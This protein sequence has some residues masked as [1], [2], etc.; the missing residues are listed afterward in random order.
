MKVEK[1][2][3][4]ELPPQASYKLT[5]ATLLGSPGF[6]RVWREAGGLDVCWCVVDS[7]EITTVMTGVEFRRKP[8]IRFQSMPDGLYCRPV[9]L[10]GGSSAEANQALLAALAKAGYARIYIN[11]FERRFEYAHGFK[12]IDGATSLVD[13]AADWQPPDTTMRSEL[14]K[15]EREG[16]KVTPFDAGRHLAQFVELAGRTEHRHG[17]EPKYTAAFY[18]HLAVVAFHE[19]RIRWF[20]VEHGQRLA[21]SHI[22]FIEGSML[23]HWQACFDKEFSFLKPNQWLTY[24]IARQAAAGGV[25]TLNLGASPPE[26]EGLASYKSHWGGRPF[27]YPCLQRHSF[28]GR[29]L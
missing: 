20:V 22:Y 15:A 13:I 18:R 10:R 17:R 26:A 16:V 25:R 14:R 29:W 24:S 4:D 12:V 8:L 21:A 27:N 2:R 23:L 19:P 11:D 28:T 1:I 5:E 6:A 3:T 7:G 9:T